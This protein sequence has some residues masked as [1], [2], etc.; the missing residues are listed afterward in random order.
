MME[1]STRRCE[2]GL[3]LNESCELIEES[4]FYVLDKEEV[5]ILEVRTQCSLLTKICQ[6]HGESFLTQHTNHQR[7]CCVPRCLS[8]KFAHL[9]GRR[10]HPIPMRSKKLRS[11]LLQNM[12]VT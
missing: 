8:K 9:A 12:K 6:G 3:K 7:A 10:Y 1:H 4:N 2:I 11:K 5:K